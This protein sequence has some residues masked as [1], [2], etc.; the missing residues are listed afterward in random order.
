VSGD[1]FAS[2]SE[3]EEAKTLLR[4]ALVE[5][6]VHAY[7]FHG[8]AGVGKL[9]TALVFA[10]EL[11]DE[12]ERVLRGAH[13][14]LY[15]LEPVGD[16]IRI[17]DVRALRH[18]LHLRPFEAERRVYLVV[19]AELMNR[20]ASDALLKDLEEPPSYAVIVLITNEL[21][22]ISATI[23]SRCQPVPFHRLSE[24]AVRDEIARRGAGGSA[25][26]QIALAR[27]ACGRLDRLERLLEPAAGGRRDRLLAIARSVY[28]DPAFE[29]VGAARELMEQVAERGVEARAKAEHELRASELPKREL[30]Q[31]LRR[32][33]RGAEREE[34]LAMLEEL[35]AWYRDLVAVAVGAEEVLVHRDRAAELREDGT[36]ERLV[37]AQEA[38][39]SVRAARRRLAAF[40]I[41][42]TLALEALFVSLYELFAG[43]E[44]LA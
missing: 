12:R 20:E 36:R 38:A 1:P 2:V 42:S 24:R 9:E 33:A 22:R 5:E 16:Q 26:E 32:V 41:N 19:S 37:A 14:D 23:R 29:P 17:D 43:V 39:E 15:L 28:E 18:D 6:P 4:T 44:A 21:S 35:A 40:N 25:E 3:Q 8:P 31:R 27:I 34:L 7:L 11:L 13:P 30:E 10:A